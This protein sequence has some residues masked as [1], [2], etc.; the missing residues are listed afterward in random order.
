MKNLL[1]CCG[2]V[3][4]RISASEKDLPVPNAPEFICPINFP[5]QKVLDFHE[6]ILHVPAHIERGCFDYPDLS[7]T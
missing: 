7:N 5:S 2:L 4:A 6:K 1:S 3:D